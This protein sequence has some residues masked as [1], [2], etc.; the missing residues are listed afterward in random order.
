MLRAKVPA[1]GGLRSGDVAF[2][3]LAKGVGEAATGCCAL[4][5][6]TVSE[7]EN[8]TLDYL[9]RAANCALGATGPLI[10]FSRVTASGAACLKTAAE[11]VFLDRRKR[12]THA[13]SGREQ[14]RGDNIQ[15]DR[16]QEGGREKVRR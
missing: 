12:T 4:F 3:R 1:L 2:G 6:P 11:S 9:N 5:Q 7:T 15:E 10:I 13:A 14:Q 8:W 16:D